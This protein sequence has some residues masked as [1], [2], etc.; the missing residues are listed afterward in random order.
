M[1]NVNLFHLFNLDIREELP[2]CAGDPALHRCRRKRAIFTSAA[3]PDIDRV[4]LDPFEHDR[5]TVILLDVGIKLVNQRG[6]LFLNSKFLFRHLG[7]LLDI[8]GFRN[9]IIKPTD[10]QKADLLAVKN[11]ESPFYINF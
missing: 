6:D 11:D 9:H 1:I 4:F 3:Q 10:M 5:S 8:S 7:S 2:Q